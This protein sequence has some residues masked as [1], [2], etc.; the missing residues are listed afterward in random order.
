MAGQVG[1]RP[2]GRE[3]PWRLRA[4]E[5]RRRVRHRVAWPA[6][7]DHLPGRA[8]QLAAAARRR[9]A[10]LFVGPRPALERA[11][12]SDEQAASKDVGTA[13]ADT[14]LD[15]TRAFW[16]LVTATEAVRVVEQALELVD[17]HLPMCATC[18]RSAWSRPTTSSASRRSGRASWCCSSRRATAAMWP[19]P[20]CAGSRA[21][22][23]R[24]RS[25]STPCSRPRRQTFPGYDA[26]LA[27]AQLKRPERQALELR[28]DGL[29]ESG[30]GRGRRPQAHDCHRRAVSTTHA[31]TRGFPARRRMGAFLGRQRQPGVALVGRRPRQG[32]RG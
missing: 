25:R 8:R 16:V 26:L 12:R 28:I 31:R 20:T 10:G 9:V 27:E 7:H 29:S 24:S 17:A 14:R 2:A 11:S 23:P 21:S 30:S 4:H 18:A 6:A 22:L 5:P 32:R 19:R 15:A 1:G 3:R 13:R